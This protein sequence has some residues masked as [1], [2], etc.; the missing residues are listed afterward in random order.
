MT[1]CCHQMRGLF[2][3]E[4]LSPGQEVWKWLS[5]AVRGCNWAR[6][7]VLLLAHVLLGLPLPVCILHSHRRGK[8]TF[9]TPP[10]RFL[11]IGDVFTVW[12]SGQFQ[13][14]GRPHGHLYIR[15]KISTFY[16]VADNQT[17]T[18]MVPIIQANCNS[19]LISSISNPPVPYKSSDPQTPGP[20]P[21]KAVQYYRG[22]TAVL[23]LE[24]YNDTAQLSD[25]TTL[26]DTPLPT[27]ID[28][29]LL[30]CLNQTL[31]SSIPLVDAANPTA[32]NFGVTANAYAMGSFWLLYYL[33][34][35]ML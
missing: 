20:R 7:P 21:E 3:D 25:D 5:R 33:V 15:S 13:S 17:A 24:G 32:W 12:K 19:S 10:L 35:M 2:T 22:S 9:T 1:Y 23:M 8:Y 16:F 28:A 34:S 6:F 18:T 11:N 4:I 26:P 29:T 14:G 31:G 27:N 30:S